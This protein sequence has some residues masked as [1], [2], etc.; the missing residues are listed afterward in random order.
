LVDQEGEVLLSKVRVHV[1]VEGRDLGFEIF[2]LGILVLFVLLPLGMD[3]RDA[4]YEV[5]LGDFLKSGKVSVDVEPFYFE[6]GAVVR[7]H[8][9]FVSDLIQGVGISFPHAVVAHPIEL[10]LGRTSVEHTHLPFP[11]VLIYFE[12]ID[13]ERLWVDRR[14]WIG[15]SFTLRGN[16]S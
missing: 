7:V 16:H 3:D 1:F 2:H 4:S 8:D 9:E 15:W 13:L 6:H 12:E 14:F 10:E 5:G 11:N